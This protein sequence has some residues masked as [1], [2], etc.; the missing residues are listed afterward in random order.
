MNSERFNT[1]QQ[2]GHNPRTQESWIHLNVLE[3][4]HHTRV[5]SLPMDY[6]NFI[7][8][9]FLL[10]IIIHPFLNHK[11]QTTEGIVMAA[12]LAPV[13]QACSPHS[14]TYKTWIMSCLLPNL[15]LLEYLM[16]E[17]SPRAVMSVETYVTVFWSQESKLYF[18]DM[19]WKGGAVWANQEGLH[20]GGE[21]S[22][23]PERVDRCKKEGNGII[24]GGSFFFKWMWNIFW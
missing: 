2:E 21:S 22:T 18:E 3:N 15:V 7:V 4:L 9:W 16:G 8:A 14:H 13:P 5:F 1:E 23:W 19:F 6:G 20:R 24:T 11:G 10:I 17:S 12:L